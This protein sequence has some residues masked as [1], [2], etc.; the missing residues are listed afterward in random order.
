MC[1][2]FLA[3]CCF[4][5]C[6]QLISLLIWFFVYYSMQDACDQ[7]QQCSEALL[8]SHT[9]NTATE[10]E[11]EPQVWFYDLAYRV[12]SKD[13]M[14]EGTRRDLYQKSNSGVQFSKDMRTCA[15][16]INSF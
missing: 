11:N 8:V 12:W 16:S 15:I 4:G 14:E 5:Q 6:R 9:H 3:A 2:R 13:M 10:R 1:N 7:M